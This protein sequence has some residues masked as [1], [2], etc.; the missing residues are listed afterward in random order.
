MAFS[1][2]AARRRSAAPVARV[3]LVALVALAAA[4]PARADEPAKPEV[5]KTEP[6]RADTPKSDAPPEDPKGRGSIV[7]WPTMTPAG[8][9]A[10]ATPVHR[11]RDT[12]TAIFA[13]AQELDATLRDAAQ[14]L[15]FV[16][17][18]AD[19]G[20][21][22]G[23]TRDLDLVERAAQSG[24]RGSL[25]DG[26]WVVSARIEYV[27]GDAYLVRMLAVP[28]KGKGL[29]V[30][31]EKVRAQDVSARGLVMLRDLVLVTSQ[32][33]ALEPKADPVRESEKLGIMGSIRSPGRAVLAANGA[34]F[35][36]FVAFGTE[37]ASGSDDPRLL[38]PLLALGTGTGLGVSLLAA[39]EWDISTGDAWVL[40]GSGWWSAGAGVLIAN[41]LHVEPLTDRYAWGVGGGL[42]GTGL[43][44]FALTRKRM[45][46]GDATLVNSGGA[47]GLLL[48]S[49]GDLFYRGTLDARPYTGSGYGSAAGL[50]GAG[51]LALFTKASA[52]RVLL[53]DLGAGLGALAGAAAGSPLIFKDVASGD[54]V[55]TGQTRGFLAATAAGTLVGGGVAW[56]FTRP[57]DEKPKTTTRLAPMGGV[58]GASPTREG[59][60]PIYGAGLRGIF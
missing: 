13:R 33:A 41:G 12:E 40:A 45:D 29:R 6:A 38:F 52:Q 51:T 7:I 57:S 48:G 1:L 19:A 23:K 17:D 21:T 26:T 54:Q 53:V 44:I 35:G 42:A 39:E 4:R 49:M 55:S 27:G 18:V 34:L 14:D 32:A 22:P 56:F 31:V 15:G 11:P 5:A 3:A 28:P 36:A 50:L 10:S 59:S 25:G 60:T 37:R 24:A 30:R 46:E 20:P 47:F 8:D 2:D 58:L 43:G 16:L 9:D